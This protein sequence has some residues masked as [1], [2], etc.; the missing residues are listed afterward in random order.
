MNSREE[1]LHLMNQY[2]FTFDTGD[3]NGFAELFE[4]AEWVVE[5]TPSRWGRQ[6]ALDMYANIKLYGDG[7]PKTKHLINNVELLID[8]GAG[9]ASSECYVTVLQ[10]TPKFPLQTIFCGHYFDN[11]ARSGDRWRFAK[12]V[13]RSPL[14]GDLTA[15]VK[16][17]SSIVAEE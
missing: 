7:T 3:I 6:G 9:T 15:H 2:V 13:I 8:E 1:I 4:Y 12:R 17:L 10:Q 14:V 11:F 16:E 5:G